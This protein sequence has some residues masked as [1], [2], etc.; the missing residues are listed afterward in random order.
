ML[1]DD[2]SS[3]QDAVDFAAFYRERWA[4]LRAA[5]G[6]ATYLG[7]DPEDVTQE[8][9]MRAR[10]HHH[11]FSS[12]VE[13]LMWSRRVGT[14]IIRRQ[15]RT[16]YRRWERP[17]PSPVTAVPDLTVVNPED[18]A[19]ENADLARTMARLH[20][21]H[22][23]VLLLGAEGHS[24]DDIAAILNISPAAVGMLLQRARKAA[25]ERW[26][27]V[28]AAIALLGVRFRRFGRPPSDSAQTLV[29]SVMSASVVA[30]ALVLPALGHS[31][32]VVTTRPVR[33]VVASTPA[34]G[35]DETPS[36]A[37][38]SPGRAV[39]GAT[40]KSLVPRLSVHPPADI[41]AHGPVTRRGCLLLSLC[42]T[43]SHA[44]PKDQRDQNGD[45]IYVKQ[46]KSV[47]TTEASAPICQDV[48]DNPVVGCYQDGD[49]DWT[50]PPSSPAVREGGSS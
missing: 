39:A 25:R 6:W 49:P 22:A 37:S 10:A 5:F 14:N 11:R 38:V 13:L 34:G 45:Q 20:P 43:C 24:R 46:C 18:Q 44:S 41:A 19:V 21:R 28:V 1:T 8:T 32:H 4:E 33:H 42:A 2:T 31:G 40:P 23:Q 35:I 17:H 47:H 7:I 16:A 36:G 12:D 30:A 26:A 29:A 50:P 15:A 48:A 3:P 27:K 9:M